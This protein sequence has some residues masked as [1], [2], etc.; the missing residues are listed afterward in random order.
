M[1]REFKDDE[2]AFLKEISPGRT[3]EEITDA[4]NAR[5]R[6]RDYVIPS[7]V[8]SAMTYRKIPYNGKHG[9]FQPG[10]ATRHVPIGS[11]IIAQYGIRKNGERYTYELVKVAEPNV[12]KRKSLLVWEKHYGSLPEGK[13]II[14]LDGDTLNSDVENLYAVSCGVHFRL[15]KY[16]TMKPNREFM[17][18]AIKIAE[19]EDAIARVKKKNKNRNSR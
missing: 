16:R 4:F 2:I 11:V 17:L 7:Q 10:V 1:R 8:R 14:F 19:I 18:A 15:N 3:C 12:W 13:M 5:F 9:K 6:D